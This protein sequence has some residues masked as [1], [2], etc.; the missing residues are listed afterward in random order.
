MYKIGIVGNG[1]VGSAVAYGFSPQTTNLGEGHQ[2]VK[3]FDVDEIVSS[4]EK[5]IHESGV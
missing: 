5:Q 2:D 4:V 3:I 1:F